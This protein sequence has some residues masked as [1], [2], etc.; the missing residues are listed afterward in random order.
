ME[1]FRYYDN[2]STPIAC[3]AAQLD[4]VSVYSTKKSIIFLDVFSIFPQNKNFLCV[5]MQMACIVAQL[6]LAR[7]DSAKE[8]AYFRRKP[9]NYLMFPRVYMYTLYV[10][11]QYL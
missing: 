5:S 6:D 7:I 9:P 3:S 2:V 11:A 10:P 4:L 1:L 8:L